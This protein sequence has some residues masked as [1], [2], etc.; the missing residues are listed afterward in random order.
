MTSSAQENGVEDQLAQ[1]ISASKDF[2]ELFAALDNAGNVLGS[3]KDYSA[4]RLKEKIDK[5]REA[6]KAGVGKELLLRGITRTAGLRGKVA[7]LLDNE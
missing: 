2:D 4:A 1:A 5:L 6:V 3:V 7:E